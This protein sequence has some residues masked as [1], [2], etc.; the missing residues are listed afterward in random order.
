MYWNKKISFCSKCIS[1][2]STHIIRCTRNLS[3]INATIWHIVLLS[4]QSKAHISGLTSWQRWCCSLEL[5]VCWYLARI[6]LHVW[7]SHILNQ[8]TVNCREKRLHNIYICSWHVSHM[9]CWFLSFNQHIT[10]KWSIQIHWKTLQ[11]FW[12]KIGDKNISIWAASDD[13]CQE[14]KIWYKSFLYYKKSFCGRR[15]C[16]TIDV[17]NT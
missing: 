3:D 16:N 14:W 13:G 15:S 1:R 12:M 7:N 8:I 5:H 11:E 10:L 2:W 17:F 6:N 9:W 4:R